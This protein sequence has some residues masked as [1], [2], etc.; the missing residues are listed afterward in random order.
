MSSWRNPAAYQLC[1]ETFDYVD[2]HFYVDHPQFV[3]QPW[4][5]PS[6]CANANP[7]RGANAGFEAVARHRVLSKPFTITEFN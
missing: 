4:R 2:D 6:K 1:R 3:E 5:L 7:V